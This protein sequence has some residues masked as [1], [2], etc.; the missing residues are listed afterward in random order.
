L[1]QTVT[2]IGRDFDNVGSIVC[3]IG[4]SDGLMIG[5]LLSSSAVLCALPPA[6]GVGNVTLEV[7][8][9]GVDFGSSFV[10]FQYVSDMYVS[11][12]TPSSDTMWG[13]LQV[14][15][16]GQGFEQE[17]AL[18]CK[19]GLE[20]A[21]A[22]TVSSTSLHCIVPAQSAGAKPFVV[23]HVETEQGTNALAFD[24]NPA[25]LPEEQVYA[26]VT[27]SFGAIGGGTLVLVRGHDFREESS[28]CN[29]GGHAAKT[30]VISSSEIEC[31]S[32]EH[33]QGCVS[34]HIVQEDRDVY[35]VFGKHFC[36]QALPSVKSITPSQGLWQQGQIITV[37]GENFMD[38]PSL[39]CRM[40]ES[41][42]YARW[43][44]DSEILCWLSSS[45]IGNIAI[46]VSNNGQDFSSNSITFEAKNMLH[47]EAIR[48]SVSSL[49]GGAVITV[50]L[51]EKADASWEALACRF[52][53]SYAKA[54]IAEHLLSQMTCTVPA[55]SKT[56]R[57]S[58]RIYDGDVAL[59]EAADFF[60][61]P[62]P[63]VIEI[64]PLRG[65]VSGNTPIRILGYELDV[66]LSD[67]FECRMGTKTVPGSVVSSS[68]A[69]CISPAHEFV[70][71]VPLA[72]SSTRESDFYT[73]ALVFDYDMP[74][75]VVDLVPS[76]I[77]ST[78]G[79]TVTIIGA[80]FRS[81]TALSCRFGRDSIV[82]GTYF[83][84]S[85]IDCPAP[86]MKPANASVEISNNGVDFSTS[87][88]SLKYISAAVLVGINPSQGPML[89]STIISATVEGDLP[90]DQMQCCFNI[91]CSPALRW[92]T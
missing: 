80:N 92:M 9:N 56:G 20:T 61:A 2:V 77:S 71:A 47:I 51:S 82:R 33:D 24:M 5:R 15:V 87:G 53:N 32:P 8:N 58:L 90:S 34:L 13:G 84:S 23:F 73:T 22:R 69:L 45:A 76:R 54:A 17:H 59:S 88:L 38:H 29:F 48:P 19:F 11:S 49:Q 91:K 12:V 39:L 4:S 27:P 3:K 89:G 86:M 72:I 55:A 41:L 25:E 35:D 52:G 36:F 1:A 63:N 66:S 83:S 70:G 10:L 74:A 18:W 81:S 37:T 67:T 21:K 43:I 60:F 62:T 68:E 16:S 85:H 57:V 64:F 50:H 26:S 14:T 42:V 44:S 30:R 75:V 7:S 78:L 6:R 65:P 31:V 79:A 40:G 46:E 28:V